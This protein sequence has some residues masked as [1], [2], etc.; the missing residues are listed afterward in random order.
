MAHESGPCGARNAHSSN[1]MRMGP[2]S[3]ASIDSSCDRERFDLLPTGRPYTALIC[4]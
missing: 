4:G 2:W 1:S 3:N